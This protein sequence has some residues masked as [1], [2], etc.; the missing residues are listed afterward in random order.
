MGFSWGQRG[1]GC[2][3]QSEGEH[4]GGKAPRDPSMPLAYALAASC[5][6]TGDATTPTGKGKAGSAHTLPAPQGTA[7]PP[8][9]PSR[10]LVVLCR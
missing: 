7:E 8:G 4:L 1:D 10:T 9:S 3:E 6:M 2:H 5:E